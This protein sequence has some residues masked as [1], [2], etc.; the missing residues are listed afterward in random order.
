M[1]ETLLNDE[2]FFTIM[3]KHT[4]EVLALL[5]KRGVNFSIL[6]NISEVTFSPELPED[7]RQNFKPITMFYLAG[8]TLESTQLDGGEISFEAGFGSD[9][10]GSLVSLPV[11]AILQI[12]LE[13]MPIFINLS[14]P[15]KTPNKHQK[16]KGVKRSMEALMSNPENQK[17]IKK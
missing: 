6:T 13:D 12:I 10:V 3:K 1:I 17:L 11:E 9:N 5:L 7:I 2:E 15:P 8:Y 14:S 16:E 4:H